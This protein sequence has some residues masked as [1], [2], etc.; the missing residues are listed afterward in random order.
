MIPGYLNRI[1]LQTIEIKCCVENEIGDALLALGRVPRRQYQAPHI[2]SSL[3]TV[4]K[5]QPPGRDMAP[6]EKV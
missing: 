4:W 5:V 2:S 1:R 6:L 3:S